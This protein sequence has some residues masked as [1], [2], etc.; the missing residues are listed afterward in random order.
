MTIYYVVYRAK[1][2]E[3]RTVKKDG[4][5]SAKARWSKLIKRGYT[6]VS[7]QKA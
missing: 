3:M 6:D 2:G 5:G 1:N 4:Y 7:L